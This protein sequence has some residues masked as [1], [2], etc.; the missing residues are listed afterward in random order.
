MEQLTAEELKD[1]PKHVQ[2]KHKEFNELMAQVDAMTG[3]GGEGKAVLDSAAAAKPGESELPAKGAATA[4]P[5]VEGSKPDNPPTPEGE[6]E[7]DSTGGGEKAEAPQKEAERWRTEAQRAAHNAKVNAGRLR[8]VAEDLKAKSEQSKSLEQELASLREQV[9]ALKKAPAQGQPQPAEGS[10][11]EGREGAGVDLNTRV[12]EALT[13]M[14]D[15]PDAA[16]KVDVASAIAAITDAKLT[17]HIEQIKS[18]QKAI[19]EQRANEASESFWL[20]VV[21]AMPEFNKRTEAPG[22][23]KFLEQGVYGVPRQ[24]LWNQA[25]ARGDYEAVVQMAADYESEESEADEPR[26]K[27]SRLAERAS[28][29]SPAPGRAPRQ[30]GPKT[31][32]LGEWMQK[33]DEVQNRMQRDKNDDSARA[34]HKELIAAMMDGRVT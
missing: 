26:G 5:S 23:A 2:E 25:I 27:T 31:Y 34:E 14:L 4:E 15:D 9:E 33:R 11:T 32:T 17:P 16:E 20:K 21:T 10:T 7:A 30:V 18:L 8:T 1:M 28:V 12:I 6:G 22:F 29:M 19:E 24:D 3:G 13:Q